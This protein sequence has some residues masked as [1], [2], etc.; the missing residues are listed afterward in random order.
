MNYQVKSGHW[1]V[2]FYAYMYKV[3]EFESFISLLPKHSM[4]LDCV[5]L[6]SVFQD[7]QQPTQSVFIKHRQHLSSLSRE[8]SK[9]C[10]VPSR[11]QHQPCPWKSIFSHYLFH[12]HKLPHWREAHSG[13]AMSSVY[14]EERVTTIIPWVSNEWMNW[15]P[16]ISAENSFALLHFQFCV[17][18]KGFLQWLY[19][20]QSYTVNLPQIV[21]PVIFQPI[22]IS[23]VLR[24]SWEQLV[25]MFCVI[26]FHIFEDC[27]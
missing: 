8:V 25:I 23:L 5:M 9:H 11:R 4:K 22:Y 20:L 14:Q 27:Y 19:T 12:A 26:T 6:G 17:F 2:V 7:S 1:D 10:Q 24:G 18:F 16:W 13:Y 15:R 21:S 3:E